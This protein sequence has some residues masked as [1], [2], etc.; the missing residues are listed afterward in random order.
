M[1]IGKRL[2][3][4]AAL[5]VAGALMLGGCGAQTS[6][7]GGSKDTVTIGVS[8]RATDSDFYVQWLQGLKDEAKRYNVTL[9]VKD[10]N[11]DD[12]QQILDV[13]SLAATK[14]D[15]LIVDHALEGVTPNAQQALDAD[16][17][18]VGFDSVINDDRAIKVSQSD[19]ELAKL[20]VQPLLE[21]TGG[22]AKVIYAY[23]AGFAP[24][25]RRNAEWEQVKKDNPGLE[26]VA[27]VGVVNESTAAQTAEQTKA[28]LQANPGV[29]AIFAPYDEFAKG[30]AQAVQE[31]GLS[32]AVKVY[33][34]DISDADI[35]VLTQD[36]SPWVSTA[37]TDPSNDGAV[38]FRTAYLA[39][40]K[41]T[42][43]KEVVVPPSLVTADELRKQNITSVSGLISAFPDLRTDDISAIKG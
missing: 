9:N 36:G 28:A 24:L 41:K 13:E 35:S 26:Q 29:A 43:S 39:A 22:T 8:V 18:V 31:L 4:I 38:T 1:T 10:A 12:S 7:D 15:A 25:D 14:P 40:Q 21:R 16:I 42:D 11:G 32:D 20:A 33:G 27:Q 34:V 17:P 2:T 19:A 23:V 6:S 5:A 37:T 3:G 30:A